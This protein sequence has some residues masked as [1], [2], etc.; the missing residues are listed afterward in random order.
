MLGHKVKQ[1]FDAINLLA[2]PCG[3]TVAELGS[4]LAIEKR[5]VYRVIEIL[6]DRFKFII[7][8]EKTVDGGDVRFYFEME[9]AKRL[10]DMKVANLNLTISEIIALHFLKG[11]AGLYKGSGIEA[12][13][14]RV[15]AKLDVFVPADFGERLEKIKNIFLPAVK[16][17]KDYSKKEQI[18]DR[19]TDTMLSQHTCLVEYH[20]F[21]SDTGKSF[22]IDPL[23]FF[24]HDGG[25]Y[26]FVRTT[27]YGEIRLLAVERITNIEETE[28]SFDEPTGFEPET[29]LENAFGIVYDD[30]ITVKI[31][32]SADQARY[33]QERRWAKIQNI[34][35]NKDGSIVLDMDTSGWWDVKKWVLSFGADATVLEPVEMREEI[36]SHLLAALENY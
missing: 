9:Q 18:I 1:I 24:E 23:R 29:L 30:P 7:L 22:K 35:H 4:R 12:E 26:L 15:Y 34:T 5:Q 3:T 17:A 6:E 13:I 27:S 32:F 16:F 20:S 28:D 10:M 11:H 19:L 21:S 2:Q 8:K 33:I 31:R 14:E 36:K 25:L